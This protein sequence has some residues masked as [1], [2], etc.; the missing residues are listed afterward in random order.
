MTLA[1][2]VE[3]G[4]S[5][6]YFEGAYQIE[7]L[8]RWAAPK[9]A[10]AQESTRFKLQSAPNLHRDKKKFWTSKC[11]KPAQGQKKRFELQSAPNLHRDKQKQKKQN[12]PRI[13]APSQADCKVLF[14]L[15]FVPVKVWWT[16]EVQNCC[17]LCPCAAVT[18]IIR[19]CPP[20]RGCHFPILLR[21][22]GSCT[23]STP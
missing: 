7:M 5:F 6:I 19:L 8:Q 17:F 2:L 14:Y 15:F 1:L 21:R 18:L 13:L 9:S 11:T 10:Q 16:F 3:E 4:N 12:F 20:C 22:S 23:L